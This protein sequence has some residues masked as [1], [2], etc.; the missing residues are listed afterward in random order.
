MGSAGMR[1]AIVSAAALGLGGVLLSVALLQSIPRPVVVQ[2]PD[3][4]GHEKPLD[5]A[6]FINGYNISNQRDAKVLDTYFAYKGFLGEPVSSW[7]GHEQMFRFSGL[8]Y[9][10]THPKDWRMELSNA[11]EEDLT[12]EGML[13]APGSS[14]HPA[15]RD[16]ELTQMN[17]GV[18]LQRVVGTFLSPPICQKGECWQ[19]SSKLRFEFEA[20]ATSGQQVRLAPVGLW[21]THPQ[22]R[23]T[24]INLAQTTIN[25]ELPLILAGILAILVGVGLLLKPAHSSRSL[26]I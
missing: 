19:A 14:P 5:G 9:D 8:S 1:V 15:V 17:A 6:L 26:A 13:P 3:T 4:A 11:G 2:V 23:P 12:L 7:D 16:W 25:D 24:R 20:S 22:T 10:P 21:L 18:D